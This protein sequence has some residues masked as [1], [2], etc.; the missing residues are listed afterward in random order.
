MPNEK[1]LNSGN[2]GK[3]NYVILEKQIRL[4][5]KILNFQ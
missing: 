2:F 3:T 5:W 4:F 1:K